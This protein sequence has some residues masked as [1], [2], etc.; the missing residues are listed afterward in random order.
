M[1]ALASQG[2]ADSAAAWTVAASRG[3][4]QAAFYAQKFRIRWLFL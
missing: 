4:R 2:Q 3:G 1:A